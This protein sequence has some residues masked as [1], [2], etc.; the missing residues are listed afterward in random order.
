MCG[1]VSYHLEATNGYLVDNKGI[2]Y[3]NHRTIEATS[4]YLGPTESFLYIQPPSSNQKTVSNQ[5]LTAT[6]MAHTILRCDLDDFFK[7][8]PF[9]LTLSQNAG[10]K[11]QKIRNILKN[12]YVLLGHGQQARDIEEAV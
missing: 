6:I 10:S 12:L 9:D 3:R 4:S 2:S 5:K 11:T 1:T 7:I 8:H